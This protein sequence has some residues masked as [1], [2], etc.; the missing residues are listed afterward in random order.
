MKKSLKFIINAI[1]LLSLV[2]CRFN[3][4]SS[5]LPLSSESS[6][7]N[8][9]SSE[10]SSHTSSES[11]TTS[12]NSS[13]SDDTNNDFEIEDEFDFYRTVEFDSQ[14][15]SAISSKEV[16]EGDKVT[17][18]TDPVKSGY[19]FDGWYLDGVVY[20]FN[21]PVYFDITLKAKWKVEDNVVVETVNFTNSLNVDGPLTTEAL[22]SKATNGNNPKVLVFPVRLQ[23]TYD[24][25]K[26]QTYLDDIEIAFNG[27]ETQTGWESVKSYYN[28]S[29]YGNV[30]LDIT[31]W[32]EW[33]YDSSIT[34][35]KVQNTDDDYY[36][37]TSDY[38]GP[39][40]VIDKILDKYDSQIDYSQYDSDGDDCIDAIWL[41]YDYPVDYED[42]SSVYWA[43]VT[44]FSVDKEIDGVY[45]NYYGWAG[46]DFMYEESNTY[47]QT[48][49][50]VDAHTYIHETGHLFGLDDYYDYD[51]SNGANRGMYA[52]DMMDYNVGDHCSFSKLL[53]DWVNPKVV[54]GV[55]ETTIDLK[56]FTTSGEFLMIADHE[57]TS[58]YD[59]YYL[60]EFYTNDGLNKNDEPI[61]DGLG[62][63]ILK[64]NA[65]QNIVNGSLEWN[66]GEYWTG[67]KY[68]NSDT[69]IPQIEVLYS[70]SIS[71]DGWLA[72]NNL[73]TQGETFTSDV[74][75][76]KVNSITS[77][78]ANVT[79][80]LK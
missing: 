6:S 28:E 48:N 32:D 70:G 22:P 44:Q 34:P 2:G 67:F 61:Y 46:I 3:V 37:G 76:L 12:S 14:G 74:F 60:V 38:D 50:I 63:R 52:A 13:D 58:I 19:I 11:S 55:G 35:S 33:F 45:P 72:S 21:D 62:I 80:T 68:D 71:S 20:N 42:S 17:K 64:V 23:S 31:V 43:F 56:P 18:P 1:S 77:S 51:E 7:M 57:V 4:S 25:S 16:F 66:E 75:N 69:S 78:N 10:S 47:D 26:Y 41:I 29:S 24:A 36:D 73:Y 15:G 8:E 54:K 39:S 65:Q 59:S 9:S 49:I 27:T 5:E 30:N 79:I 53:L 40:Y